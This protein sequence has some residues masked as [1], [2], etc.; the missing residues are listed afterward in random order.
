MTKE[1]NGRMLAAWIM[2]CVCGPLAYVVGKG[3][4]AETFI[5]VAISTLLAIVALKKGNFDW[6]RFRWVAVV[7]CLFLAVVA[8]L[9]LQMAA[10]AWPHSGANGF[11]PVTLLALSVIG[12]GKG[13]KAAARV[14]V[15]LMWILLLLFVAMIAGGVGNVRAERIALWSGPSAGYTYLVALLPGVACLLPRWEGKCK[16]LWLLPVFAAV[17]SVLVIG[18]LSAPVARSQTNP[19]YEYGKSLSLLGVV[20]RYEAFVSVALTL[21]YYAMLSFLMS[22][23]NHLGNRL[24][25]ADKTMLAV[26]A[27][28]ILLMNVPLESAYPLAVGAL[29][30][31]YIIPVIMHKTCG[32][33]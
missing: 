22:A 21:S 11:V 14:G 17:M 3:S 29:V 8:S 19:L 10:N 24:L 5:A 15:M 31:W 28:A 1:L 7:E 2:A 12:A 25:G 20:E 30:L 9:V 16:C 13:A 26:A 23:V 33:K 32:A 27:G 6:I 4:V 18:T